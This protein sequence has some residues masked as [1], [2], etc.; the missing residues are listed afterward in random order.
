MNRRILRMEDDPRAV[1]VLEERY[2]RDQ[3]RGF[4]Q[5]LWSDLPDVLESLAARGVVPDDWTHDDR[6]EFLRQDWRALP[7]VLRNPGALIAAERLLVDELARCAQE[8]GSPVGSYGGVVSWE[9]LCARAHAG[10]L[11]HNL[12][13]GNEFGFESCR[14][15]RKS[16]RWLDATRDS[17]TSYGNMGVAN[18]WRMADQIASG[19]PWIVSLYET[20]L[21]LW[22]WRE[23]W[24][25]CEWVLIVRPGDGLPWPEY[26]E[27]SR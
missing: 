20:G 10:E 27:T 22:C 21:G 5:S 7:S 3:I 19:A 26:E 1:A 14:N 25:N 8:H 18:A 24:G 16:Q 2:A 4:S 17:G 12:P 23:A 11:G 13:S 9:S 15:V 6:V